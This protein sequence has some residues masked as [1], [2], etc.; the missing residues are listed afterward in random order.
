MAKEPDV[1]FDIEI[2]FQIEVYLMWNRTMNKLKSSNSQL[3]NTQVVH[4]PL[5]GMIPG[6][7]D[8]WTIKHNSW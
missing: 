6:H 5:V 7:P 1:N 2:F 4:K 3:T 8:L